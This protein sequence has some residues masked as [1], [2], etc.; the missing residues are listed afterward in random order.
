MTLARPPSLTS[1]HARILDSVQ[2]VG[3]PSVA[4]DRKHP[5]TAITIVNDPRFHI[6]ARAYDAAEV[7]GRAVPREAT[8]NFRDHVIN[9][10]FFAVRLPAYARL[11]VIANSPGIEWNKPYT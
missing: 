1:P 7:Q 6:V 10:Q 8:L 11:P 5:S 2:H 3:L 4:I 9:R